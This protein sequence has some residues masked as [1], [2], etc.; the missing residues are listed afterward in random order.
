MKTTSANKT[1]SKN[2]TTTRPPV[3]PKDL[4][5][6]MIP[7]QTPSSSPLKRQLSAGRLRSEH[8]HKD[9]TKSARPDDSPK[10]RTPYTPGSATQSV[11]STPGS[12]TTPYSSMTT[13]TLPTPVS[14]IP[15]GSREFSRSSRAES[16]TPTSDTPTEVS[17]PVSA[18]ESRSSSSTG[19]HRRHASDSSCIA[20]S[21][22]DRGRPR[23]GVEGLKGTES[24][25]NKSAER[26]AFE[27]LP[28]GWKVPDA[29][30]M[31]D[32]FETAA[33]NR[34]A[35]QQVARFE[36]LRKSDVDSLSRVSCSWL[37]M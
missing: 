30:K 4:P 25:K 11:S 8:N 22:M 35:L 29:V 18:I 16:I 20:G 13:S 10:S 32:S 17:V 27:Y 19:S 24:K 28:K 3:S 14:P 7:S 15:E 23:K 2:S 37:D 9:S 26:R 1:E 21:I 31:L 34:Q 12:A 5:P 33:L 6:L 36:I